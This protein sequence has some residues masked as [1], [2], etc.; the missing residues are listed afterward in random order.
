MQRFPS[1]DS[2]ANGNR[3]PRRQ[4]PSH[5]RRLP[6][7]VESKGPHRQQRR[8]P[9]NPQPPQS[10]A[11]RLPETHASPQ[12]TPGQPE[13]TR[14]HTPLAFIPFPSDN[15]RF[16]VRELQRENAHFQRGISGSI[17]QH[18]GST[19]PPEGHDSG[20]ARLE[21]QRPWPPRQNAGNVAHC[22]ATCGGGRSR[23]LRACCVGTLHDLVSAFI[24]CVLEIVEA[25]T[26]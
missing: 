18:R 11:A 5:A 1:R 16:C 3:Q 24:R 9:A 15:C 12:Q 21:C 20:V 26:A 6:K 14:H 8:L 17:E 13:T 2:E 25:T 19:P 7:E 22:S 23:S 4:H 10:P